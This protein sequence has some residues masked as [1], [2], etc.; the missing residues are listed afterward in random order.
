MAAAVS[1]SGP[2]HSCGGTQLLDAAVG[3]STS[4]L[5]SGNARRYSAAF[6][7]NDSPR[8]VL[9]RFET[10]SLTTEHQAADA[11][12]S[13]HMNACPASMSLIPP[14]VQLIDLQLSSLMHSTA[15]FV[16]FCVVN[17]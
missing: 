2:L 11:F 4:Q 6:S 12:T 13:C 17:C 14:V 16:C 9:S 10:H 8:H 15:Y 7:G 1:L 5:K 3:A